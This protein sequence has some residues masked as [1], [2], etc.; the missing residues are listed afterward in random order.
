[1]TLV[2]KESQHEIVRVGFKVRVSFLVHREPLS[3]E[4]LLRFLFYI[5]STPSRLSE[6]K[7][8]TQ[9]SLFTYNNTNNVQRKKAHDTQLPGVPTETPLDITQA[10]VIPNHSTPSSTQPH[11][12]RHHVFSTRSRRQVQQGQAWRRQ[13]LLEGSAATECRGRGHGHVG[14]T[15]LDRQRTRTVTDIPTGAARESR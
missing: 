15:Y 4:P 7:S 8:R 1:M 14:R 13:A 3:D 6:N 2:Y 12:Y 5:R 10:R 11:T 9:S